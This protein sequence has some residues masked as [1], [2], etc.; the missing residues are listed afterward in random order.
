MNDDGQ[1][2]KELHRLPTG[3]VGL[4]GLLG[5]GLFRGGLYLVM[6][7][8]GTGKTILGNHLCFNHVANGG[9]ATYVTLLAETHADLLMYLEPLAFFDG[10]VVAD[11]LHYFNGYTPLEQDGLGG[12]LAFL[13][14]VILQQPPSLLVIDAL[15]T[16]E[17]AAESNRAFRKFLQDL[18]V[19]AQ[20]IDCTVILL[21]PT[22]E[23]TRLHPEHMMVDGLIELSNVMTSHRMIRYLQVHKFRGSGFIQGRHL[24]NITSA[25]ITLYLRTEAVLASP[26]PLT[27]ASS[28]RLGVGIDKF[29]EMLHGG[30]L[31]GSVTLLAGLPGS[32]K[33]SFGQHFLA[34][35]AQLGQPGL[36]FGFYEMPSHL[37]LNADQLGL[38]FSTYDQNGLLNILW[39]QA[40]A[41]NANALA[42]K[43]LENV[44]RRNVTRLVIDGFIGFEQSIDNPE[45]LKF[46]LTTLMNEL[47]SLGVTTLISVEIPEAFGSTLQIPLGGLSTLA[48]NI[49]L[50]RMVEHQ[51]QLH[52][53]VSILKVRRSSY[54]STIR[55]F[56][57][58]D[59]GVQ[60][61][62]VF[63]DAQSILTGIATT[64]TPRSKSSTRRKSSRR[65]TRRLS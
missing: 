50:L 2:R 49:V 34:K 40:Y 23:E 14:Q 16:V 26:N 51:S 5:G 3:I 27:E 11:G 25:G 36:Y 55:K 4:D 1:Q 18:H 10:H 47:R 29:D 42:Q 21:T 28:E 33:T 7:M 32:G 41:Y 12:L 17:V 58:T 31:S 57:I 52:R 62:E 54:D 63:K 8:P 13:R 15:V 19:F 44:R 65:S 43:L 60:I 53:A 6:G 56:F 38:N 22:D 9:R 20:L 30:L 35:G 64:H 61:D 45:R 59:R 48:D 24:L 46:F 37:I 39:Q